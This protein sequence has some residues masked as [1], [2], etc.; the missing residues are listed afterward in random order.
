MRERQRK[1]KYKKKW[2]TQHHSKLF[3]EPAQLK[4]LVRKQLYGAG[5]MA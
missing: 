4:V 3:Q 1:E 2:T 5:M